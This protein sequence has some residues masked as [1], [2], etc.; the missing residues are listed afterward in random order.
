MSLIV[1]EEKSKKL[2]LMT[3]GADSIMIP[4][5]TMGEK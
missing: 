4:R 1:R 3:K 2:I 5:T